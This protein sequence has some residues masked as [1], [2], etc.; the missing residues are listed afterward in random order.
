LELNMI[1]ASLI[2]PLLLSTQ[3]MASPERQQFSRCLRTFVD[4]KLEERLAVDAFDAALAGACGPQEAA[5]RAAYVAA[6]TRMGDTRARADQDAVTEIRD[7][8]GNFKEI[9][10]DSQPQPQPQAQQAQAPA[11]T[12]PQAQP[13]VQAQP[14]PQQ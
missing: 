3:I 12:Q 6:A 5:Y 7:L 13:A 4:A 2:V 11:Q 14:E 8:R 1:S 9:F 10:V